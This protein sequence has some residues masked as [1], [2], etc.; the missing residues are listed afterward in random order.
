[1]SYNVVRHT[2]LRQI[3]SHM[4]SLDARSTPAVIGTAT[5]S[6]ARAVEAGSRVRTRE[7]RAGGMSCRR[8][9]SLVTPCSGAA[10]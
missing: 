2:L 6:F 3:I 9:R 1:M 5:E 8:E 7:V 4:P 10:R